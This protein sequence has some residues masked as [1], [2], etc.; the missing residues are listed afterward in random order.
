V[1]K[2]AT[3]LWR[4][5]QL[6]YFRRLAPF[7]AWKRWLS[8]VLGAAPLLW[9]TLAAIRRN[10]GVYSSGAM[11]FGH[12]QLAD[13]CGKCHGD[14]WLGIQRLTTANAAD[15]AMNRACLHCHGRSID[16]DSATLTAIHQN[17]ASLASTSDSFAACADCH[18]EHMGVT[19]LTA[20]PDDQCV[21]CHESLGETAPKTAFHAQISSFGDDHSEFR[22]LT[23]NRKDMARMKL[24][25]RVH[26]ESGLRGPEG[27]RVQMT[28]G[29]CHRAER[30][31]V[32]WPYGRPGVH[33]TSG[34]EMPASEHEAQGEFMQ[35][36]RYSLHCI[37]CHELVADPLD[38]RLSHGG[39]VPHDSPQTI[40]TYLWGQL[41]QY[42]Q[43][44]PDALESKP[45][46]TGQSRSMLEW[47]EKE[48]AVLERK[49]YQDQKTCLKCHEQS[50][51]PGGETL[52][53][54]MDPEI[55]VRWFNHGMFNHER[56]R[57]VECAACHGAAATSTQT[58]DVLLPGIE[59]CRTCHAPRSSTAAG[60]IGGTDHQCVLCHSYHRPPPSPTL[61][62]GRSIRDI[63]SERS[64]SN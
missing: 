56:H 19:R 60:M 23:G 22:I 49:L 21:R 13:Q 3:P 46:P 42:L 6:D 7:R 18:R 55:P 53:E 45:S 4:S 9:I 10:Q 11:S 34:S 40:R 41:T 59:T 43:A 50:T 30:F 44:H 26:L 48:V 54:I 31:A 39:V 36:I 58:G 16:H 37:T 62:G 33:D 17:F 57:V 25:H 15:Q 1:S 24:N 29:D 61:D 5:I 2:R 12:A 27:R 8:I 14:S 38:K 32:S 20:V 52:P 28:C 63:A 64:G 47:L 35:P 51:G